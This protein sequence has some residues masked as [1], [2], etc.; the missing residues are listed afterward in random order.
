MIADRRFELRGR[1]YRETQKKKKKEKEKRRLFQ[2]RQMSF[3]E[4]NG[5][6]C[7]FLIHHSPPSLSTEISDETRNQE[8]YNLLP[9][10]ALSGNPAPILGSCLFVRGDVGIGV[11]V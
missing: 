10:T 1:S 8:V 5:K 11:G 9:Y 2:T 6:D 4:K 3:L 7:T